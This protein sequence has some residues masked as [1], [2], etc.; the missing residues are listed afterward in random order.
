MTLTGNESALFLS[1]KVVK[2]EKN[3]TTGAIIRNYTTI[4][5]YRTY[6]QPKGTKTTYKANFLGLIVFSISV[7]IVVGGLGSEASAFI[8]FITTL[9]E[10]VMKLVILVMW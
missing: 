5:T 2:T 7:G 8:D 10:V 1:D 3:E 6:K 9:N 4:K